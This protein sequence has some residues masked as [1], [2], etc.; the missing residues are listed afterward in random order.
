M[1]KFT[2]P[3]I[4]LNPSND[5]ILSDYLLGS[6]DVLFI[7]FSGVKFL[8]EGGIDPEVKLNMPEIGEVYVEG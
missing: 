1:F 6:G 5:S 4:S 3:E 7:Y 8:L 2:Y